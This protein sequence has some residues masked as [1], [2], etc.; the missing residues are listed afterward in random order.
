MSYTKRNRK[1]LRSSSTSLIKKAMHYPALS[2]IRYDEN[3]KSK[4]ADI[5]SKSGYK[6][7]G[8]VAVQRKLLELIYTIYK[9]DTTYDP[10]YE[11]KK[12]E[13]QKVEVPS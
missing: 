2:A 1:M 3:Y 4:Y 10:N 9:N 13:N 7:K 8:V 11:K 5:V 12:R 6:M